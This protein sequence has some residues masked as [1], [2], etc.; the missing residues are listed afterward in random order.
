MKE[1]GL[2]LMRR[3]VKDFNWFVF[4]VCCLALPGVSLSFSEKT[5]SPAVSKV[6]VIVE[7]EGSQ[8]NFQELIPIKEGELF[9]LKKLDDT[10][11]QIYKT[12]LFSDV[13][14]L[15][16]GQEEVELTFL[17]TRKLLI[18]KII[19]LGEK[20]LPK[21]K[22]KES[23]YS[24]RPESFFS[25]EKLAKAT[26]ELRQALENAGYFHSRLQSRFQKDMKKPLVDAF[27][28]IFPGQ[29]YITKKLDWEGETIVPQSQLRQ[30]IATQEG[31]PFIPFELDRDVARLKELYKSLGYERAEIEVRDKI[32]DEEEKS[33]LLT[34]RVK[35]NEKIKMTIKGAD[36]PQDILRPIWEERIFEEW[37]LVQGEARILAYLRK[38]GYIFTAINSRI[39]NVPNEIE[40]IHEVNL[41]HRYRIQNISFEGLHY[42]A[43]ERL[44]KELGIS[45]TIPFLTGLDGE[46][47]FEMP[48]KIEKLYATY[49]FP[50]TLVDLSFKKEGKKMTAY[51]SIEEGPQQRI[52]ALAVNGV[53][54]FSPEI[55]MTKI[56]SHRDG[57]FFQPSL[58]RDIEILEGFYLDQGVRGT[59]V[60]AKVEKVGEN[61]FSVIFDIQEGQKVKIEK[62][63][64]TGN[65]VTMKSTIAKELRIREGD[66]AFYEAI[67]ETKRNLE[68]LGIFSE[69]RVEEIPISLDA[70]NLVINLREGER[71]YVGLGVGL[72]TKNEP[73]TFAVWDNVI[74][75]RGTIEFIRSNIF[76][77]AAQ[78]SLVTQF[79][80]KEKRGVISWEEPYFLGIHL[81]TYLNAW[82][83][84]EEY[85]SYGYDQRGISLTGAKSFVRGFTLLTTLRWASTSLYFLDIAESEIDRQHYP[86]STT[87]LSESFI[88]DRRDDTFNPE[89]GSFL[90]FVVE[91][92]YPL[93]KVESDYLK[94][95]V[96]YQHFFPIF[97]LFNFSTT[98]RFG[99]GRGRMPIHERFFGGGSNSFRGEE[100]DK[101]GPKD[102]HSL[103]PV[104]G[105]ALLLFNFELRFSIFSSL[106]DLSGA[107]FYDKGNIFAKRKDVSFSGLQDAVGFGLRYRTP[108]GPLRFDLGWNLDAPKGERQPIAFIT[109][110]NVF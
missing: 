56:T 74:R 98:T 57:P 16:E 51:F 94:T 11:K 69:V 27:F 66:L 84:R 52:E 92:A 14:V 60:T 110:G 35:P 79:S 22:L 7:G 44:K 102:P 12:G 37:G 47:I 63:I 83:E 90:S 4:L 106:K 39:N 3:F 1:D 32:F 45:Q 54:L 17:L 30:R 18:R 101:L 48:Q 62:I 93:F 99:L 72:E 38:K 24:L 40:V 50:N 76:G 41:G 33:V 108:L 23:I 64:I 2:V 109:I 105:K 61:L 73:Q 88:W 53:L 13:Q 65:T 28:E 36:V 15:K 77:R 95:F 59:K 20:S 9:S 96:K 89:R 81:Q 25:P 43:P 49:G 21:K 71:N 78:L 26:E 87:S 70:E 107:F 5:D 68:K 91:W 10:L 29:R 97:S 6:S 82:L 80:L 55:L 42:F 75:P 100:F 34:L 104:G 8:K 19:L 31:R 85:T 67:L 103:M 46:K 58:Q 86:F